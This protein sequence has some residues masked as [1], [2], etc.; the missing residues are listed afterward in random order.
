MRSAINAEST[1]L[2]TYAR[3]TF[4][5]RLAR[6]H[7]CSITLLRG[8][9]SRARAVSFLCPR[10]EHCVTSAE[11]S[12]LADCE[13]WRTFPLKTAENKPLTPTEQKLLWNI[14]EHAVLEYPSSAMTA[15]VWRR[16]GRKFG[17]GGGRVRGRGRR[18]G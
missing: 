10:D 13:C 1:Y 9:L 8:G 12:V 16:K 5:C 14:R 2:H 18:A 11:S 6:L 4:S 17:G 7:V 3:S 15:E